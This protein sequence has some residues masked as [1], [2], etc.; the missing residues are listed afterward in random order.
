MAAQLGQNRTLEILLQNGA[1][2]ETQN[3]LGRTPLHTAVHNWSYN[4]SLKKTVE[5]LIQNGAKIDA[6]DIHGQTPIQ[7]AVSCKQSSMVQI[8][9]RYGASLKIRNQDGSTPLEVALN[10][11]VF[12]WNHEQKLNLIKLLAYSGM[13]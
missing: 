13:M 6:K 11:N 7:L 4:G 10:V 8:L 2:I 12:S 5:I 9:L 1:N 3:N